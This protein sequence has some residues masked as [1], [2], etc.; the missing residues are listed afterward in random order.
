MDEAQVT[1]EFRHRKNAQFLERVVYM[2]PWCGL[3][4]FESHDD[5]IRCTKC[6][7]EIRHKAN[8]ELEGIGKPFPHR[9]VADWYDWQNNYV[10]QLDTAS[11]ADAP[12]WTETGA[13]SRVIPEKRKELLT[14]EATIQLYGDRIRVDGRDFSFA[15]T[16]V[17]LLGKNKLNLY[18]G[19]D[20]YQIKSGK[21]FNALKYLNFYHRFKNLQT[22]DAY[23]Q[24]LGL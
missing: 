24:F 5:V 10:N 14:K 16:A 9:F 13:F 4:T 19:K 6:G 2:C 15:T 1:G 3:S 12:I 17:T 11:M 18:S 7:L 22:G 20:I 8:K 21:R 23:E